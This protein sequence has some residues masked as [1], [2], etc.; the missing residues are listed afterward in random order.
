MIEQDH[1]PTISIKLVLLDWLELQPIPENVMS[2]LIC[3][4][5]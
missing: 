3:P 1:F 2:N 4:R 5:P